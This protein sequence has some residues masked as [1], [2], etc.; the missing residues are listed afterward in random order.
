MKLPK[1]KLPTI[2]TT[3]EGT[4]QKEIIG[5]TPGEWVKSTVAL[6]VLYAILA[7]FFAVLL[8]IAQT[9][10]NKGDYYVIP[11]TDDLGV[12]FENEDE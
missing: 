10:R 8:V 7:G 12:D 2:I 6:C 4:G 9:I 3:R 11:G 1:L 5:L